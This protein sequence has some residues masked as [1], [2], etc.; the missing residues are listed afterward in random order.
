MC[1]CGLDIGTC[2]LVSATQ[3]ESG[4]TQV[5]SI[6]NSFLEIEADASVLNMLKMSNVS[7]VQDGNSVIVVGE[8]ALSIANLLK[9][10]IRRPMSLG[11]ISPGE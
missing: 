3:D 11:V 1:A 10:N 8:M 7:Y 9:K 5:K 2:F 6:R 4:Q